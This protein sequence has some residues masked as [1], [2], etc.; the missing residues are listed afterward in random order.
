M[1]HDYDKNRL[2][3]APMND[4]KKLSKS[5]RDNVGI[6]VDDFEEGD[7]VAPRSIPMKSA[8]LGTPTG[9]LPWWATMLVVA[10]VFVAGFF[11]WWFLLKTY[12]ED[13]YPDKEW[14]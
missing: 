3:I 12:C 1:I 9:G 14:T 2:G 5:Q 4:V 8:I 13:T 11:L 10:S 6:H 7:V